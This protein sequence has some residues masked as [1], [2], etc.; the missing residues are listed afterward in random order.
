MG[1]ES[2]TQDA[3]RRSRRRTVIG[4]AVVAGLSAILAAILVV[5]VLVSGSDDGAGIAPRPSPVPLWRTVGP[6]ALLAIS[7]VLGGVAV[8]GMVRGR[9]IESAQRAGAALRS[10]TRHE[11]KQVLRQIR[12]QQPADP[13]HLSLARDV[14]QSRVDQRFVLFSILGTALAVV[15]MLFLRNS[16]HSHVVS[17]V[18]AA[19]DLPVLVVGAPLVI[20]EVRR[21]RR[22][23]RQNPL[24]VI[25]D[26]DERSFDP[27]PNLTSTNGA[28][29][30]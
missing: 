7:L 3:R 25:E 13:V 14:A 12:G 26:G 11:R 9:H 29:R 18:A 2:A 27:D 30:G 21:A 20:R 5:I 16:E 28:D 10:L 15:A 22:F 19:V 4:L 8:A 23:L 6:F 1:S 17:I 24:P